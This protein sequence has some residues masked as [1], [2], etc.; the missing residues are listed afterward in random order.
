[1]CIL[2]NE[3]QL[4]MS[5]IMTQ[6]LQSQA[7]GIGYENPKLRVKEPRFVNR[8]VTLYECRKEFCAPS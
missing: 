5:N 4:S 7:I 3:P 6:I 2:R 1:V 8:N